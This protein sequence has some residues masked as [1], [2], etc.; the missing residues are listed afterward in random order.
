VS[1]KDS[2]SYLILRQEA[3]QLTLFDD[4]LKPIVVSEFIGNNNTNIQYM[5]YG[6]G[7]IYIAITDTSQDLSFVYDGQ[8][9]LLTIIPVESYDIA[10]R[11]LDFDR[12]KLYSVLE[13][14]LTI[15]SF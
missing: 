11:P 9:K 2:K 7:K 6:A 14:V 12:V 5:D 13:K 8:G 4:N 1:E 3:K 10:V 15:Q